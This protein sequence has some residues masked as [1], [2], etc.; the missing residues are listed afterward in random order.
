MLLIN[1]LPE[2]SRNKESVRRSTQLYRNKRVACKQ[3]L[4]ALHYDKQRQKP[5]P[6]NKKEKKM[7]LKAKIFA[8]PDHLQIIILN[9]QKRNNISFVDVK[10]VLVTIRSVHASKTIRNV[11]L[12]T[13]NAQ[14]IVQINNFVFNKKFVKLLN[15]ITQS[16]HRRPS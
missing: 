1:L 6:I 9:D 16:P 4:Q 14:Q 5:Y 3:Q 10:R 12:D 2:M 13:V 15:I 8:D 7:R 11:L